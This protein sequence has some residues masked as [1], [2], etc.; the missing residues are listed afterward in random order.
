MAVDGLLGA[1]PAAHAHAHSNRHRRGATSCGGGLVR[2][3]P[4]AVPRP[5]HAPQPQASVLSG[6]QAPRSEGTNLHL[7]GQAE[8]RESPRRSSEHGSSQVCVSGYTI[9]HG[10]TGHGFLL[11]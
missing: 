4:P 10:R 11:P 9:M 7:E 6:A 5:Q 1:A 2:A 8:M 3:G